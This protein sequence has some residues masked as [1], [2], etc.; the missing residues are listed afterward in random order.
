VDALSAVLFAAA[1]L[2]SPPP[3]SESIAFLRDAEG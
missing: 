3:F 2:L 1:A